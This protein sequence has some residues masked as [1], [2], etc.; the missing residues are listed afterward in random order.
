MFWKYINE[1]EE[2]GIKN[3][4]KDVSCKHQT[5]THWWYN[6]GPPSATLAQAYTNIACC[7]WPVPQLSFDLFH[8]VYF[9]KWS[10]FYSP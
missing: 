6:A 8:I 9:M 4:N 5:F 1:Q 7:S 2:D 3:K 10:H